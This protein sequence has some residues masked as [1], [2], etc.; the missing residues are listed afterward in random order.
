MLTSNYVSLLTKTIVQ[1]KKTGNK[2]H[3]TGNRK[4][5]LDSTLSL[6]LFYRGDTGGSDETGENHQ[7]NWNRK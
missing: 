6:R 3:E 7:S 2:R 1:K 4:R 5:E